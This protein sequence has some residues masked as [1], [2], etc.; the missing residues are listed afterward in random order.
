[1]KRILFVVSHIGSG[2][3]KLIQVLNQNPRVQIFITNTIYEHPKDLYNLLQFQHKTDDNSAIY[4]D[5]LLFNSNLVSKSFYDICKFIY[6]IREAKAS[7]NLNTYHPKNKAESYY[8]FRLRRIYEM[9]RSTKDAMFLDWDEI[10][11]GQCFSQLEDYLKLKMPLKLVDDMEEP[12]EERHDL[13]TV[14]RAQDTYEKYSY[15][16]KSVFSK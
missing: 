4:G 14:S 13:A 16:I 9:A 7:L 2:S 15:K 8:R 12:Y 11:S 1:M 5:H 6:I 3:N 10:K